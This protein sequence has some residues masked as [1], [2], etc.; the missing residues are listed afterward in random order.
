[1]H[2]PLHHPRRAASRR[3][4]LA[5]AAL[6]SVCRPA[7]S[8]RPR[9]RP[10]RPRPR[11]PPPARRR[12]ARP[13]E[14]TPTEPERRAERHGLHDA[15]RA[16]RL[17]HA[18]RPAVDSCPRRPAPRPGDA[19]PSATAPSAPCRRGP[20]R[21]GRSPPRR[22]RGPADR[23][24]RR[25]HRAHARRRRRP[26]RATPTSPPSTA[27]T[28][29]TPM[30]ALDAAGA[31]ATQAD[32]AAR[33][34][35][36]TTSAATSA[37]TTTRPYAGPTAKAVLGV[38]AQGGDPTAV[39][40]PSTSSRRLRAPSSR[41]RPVLPTVDCGFDTCDYSNT[42]G[43][44]LGVIALGRAGEPLC[45]GL[46]RLP[47]RPAVRRRRLPRE[48]RRRRLHL[49]D[50]DA[51]ALRRP[52]A[53]RRRGLRRAADE[54]STAWPTQQGPRRRSSSADEG[55]PTPTPPVS[56]PRP[57]P[58]GA[59]PPS[60]PT[61]RTSSSTLQF[62]CTAAAALRGG[63]AFT[64]ADRT[65]SR[66]RPSGRVD[67]ERRATAQATL[68]LAGDSLLAAAATAPTRPP[69]RPGL[70]RAP[71]TTATTSTD[72]ARPHGGAA[73]SAARRRPSPPVRRPPARRPGQTG[74]DL[75][76][77]LG[78][79][80]AAL[81]AA[82]PRGRHLAARRGA[83]ARA[84]PA[85]GC[86]L[87]R[88]AGTAVAAPAW[89]STGASSRRRARRRPR[90]AR[91][92]AGVTV[93]VDTGSSSSTR[94]A[95]GD[96]SSAWRRCT[97]AGYAVTPIQQFPGRPSAASTA[98]R[99]TR[100]CVRMPPAD[101]YWAFFHAHRGGSWTYSSS[102]AASYDPAPGTVVGFRVRLG[103][104]SRARR[105]AEAGHAHPKPTPKPDGR[106]RSPR[107]PQPK[108]ATTR[109]RVRRAA[110]PLRPSS[111]QRVATTTSTGRPTAP[112]RAPA[113]TARRRERLDSR[114]A[115]R[116]PHGDA[117]PRARRRRPTTA[118]TGPTAAAAAPTP[119]T[120]PVGP[121]TLLAG[122]GLVAL[123]AGAGGSA[124]WQ[125]RA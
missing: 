22:R 10:A 40:R 124:A 83:H 4:L 113:A 98:S 44:S 125:R 30:L 92:R 33:L 110:T 74:S 120:A 8:P 106:R 87:V 76:R 64:A 109:A 102:G 65:P 3:V 100:P 43:Q 71:S 123:V 6:A 62:D 72:H 2:R 122:G 118:A 11:A 31:G 9:R 105:P 27:A 67:Q 89:S 117:R 79:G 17:A 116:Q 50:P 21:P 24:R 32:A 55:T 103:R 28:P 48:P 104:S 58:P 29:S 78:L 81:V 51:T 18:E 54:R 66:P 82:W 108:P 56:P 77:P 34:P 112:P 115:R 47:A 36:A 14:P 99:P 1:M 107:P 49:S 20:L 35:R 73:T 88:L 26:L 70:R 57:S 91:A 114:R 85:A 41:R 86:R 15:R 111:P 52:G 60:S 7:P 63:I 69:R 101:A 94:C 39:R 46:G 96:P 68:G 23:L 13:S 93:V 61:R 38:L 121:A 97:A 16:D 5:A 42:I 12:R 95:A 19:G 59:G 75:L 53:R 84:S 45:R 37:P 25:L 80:L 119:P 90:P